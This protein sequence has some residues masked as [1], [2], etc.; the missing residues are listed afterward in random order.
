MENLL[1]FLVVIIITAMAAGFA[2][3]LLGIGGGMIIVPVLFNVLGF[4]GYSD[5]IAYKVS[6]GTSLATIIVTGFR[7][8]QGHLH[9]DAVDIPLL[10]RWATPIIVGSFLGGIITRYISVEYLL[11]VFVVVIIYA[12]ANLWKKETKVIADEMPENW[13]CYG[14]FPAIVGFVS[15]FMGIG[16]GTLSTPLLAAYGR[17]IHKSIGTAAAIGVLIAISSTIAMIIAGLGVEGRPHFSLGYVNMLIW[18][19]FIPITAFMAPLGAKVA[20]KI[21]PFVLKRIFACF[22]IV[23]ALRMI[24]K[25]LV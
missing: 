16:G 24:Y 8:A 6:I 12:A 13:F 1:L 15:T 18:I 7:S 21:S 25:L 11:I 3:G 22:L 10:R 20:H 5:D 17:S 4:M 19:C 2:A 9:H 23:S 14:V